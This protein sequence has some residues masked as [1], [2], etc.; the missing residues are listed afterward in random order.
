[1]ALVRSAVYFPGSVVRRLIVGGRVMSSEPRERARRIVH[2]SGLIA[3]ACP[4]T[5]SHLDLAPLAIVALESDLALIRARVAQGQ[6]KLI[7]D[8]PRRR[9]TSTQPDASSQEIEQRS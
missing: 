9:R 8:R 2:A 4:D 7:R 5:P 3:E 6:N 1:L